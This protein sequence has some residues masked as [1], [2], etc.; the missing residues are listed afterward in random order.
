MVPQSG[1]LH[2]P[3]TI[4]MSQEFFHRSVFAHLPFQ[5]CPLN[6]CPPSLLSQ[7][8]NGQRKHIGFYFFMLLDAMTSFYLV[9]STMTLLPNEVILRFRTSTYLFS[10]LQPKER[11]RE[12]PITAVRKANTFFWGQLKIPKQSAYLAP[13]LMSLCLRGSQKLLVGRTFSSLQELLEKQ[14]SSFTSCQHPHPEEGI[15]RSC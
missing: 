9:I 14:N 10:T 7:E 2:P 3:K 1:Y 6:T 15:S 11:N 4:I 13:G 8:R 12:Q 5:R